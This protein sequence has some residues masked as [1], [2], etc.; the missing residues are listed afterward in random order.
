MTTYSIGEIFHE[1]FNIK[2]SSLDLIVEPGT[3]EASVSL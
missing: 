3:R 2:V 1:I